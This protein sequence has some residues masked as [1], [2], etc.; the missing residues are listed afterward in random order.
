MCMVLMKIQL[1][2]DFRILYAISG[3]SGQFLGV[4]G[5]IVIL[6]G[7]VMRREED[8]FFLEACVDFQI[9]LT[10]MNCWICL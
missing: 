6:F 7:S 9:L 2:M 4:L 10:T 5:V 3:C 1:K 8:D